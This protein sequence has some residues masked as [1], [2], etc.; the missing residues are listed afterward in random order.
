MPTNR[1]KPDPAVIAT[2]VHQIHAAITMLRANGFDSLGEAA[3][4]STAAIAHVDGKPVGLSDIVRSLKMPFSSASRLAWG[5][6]ERGLLSYESHASDR[7][8]KVI[9]A[10]VEALR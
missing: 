9:R 4:F 5:L 3:V 10:N 1:Q 7:R 8:R 2:A 6:V